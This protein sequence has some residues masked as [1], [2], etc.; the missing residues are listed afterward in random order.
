M[1]GIPPID[2]SVTEREV[3]YKEGKQ[4]KD[5]A[6]EELVREWQKRWEKYNGWSKVFIKSCKEWTT[7][8]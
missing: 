7:K 8:Q 6:R 2:L 1:A 5:S 4:K 3:I